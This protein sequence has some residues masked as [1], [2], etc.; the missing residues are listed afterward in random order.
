MNSFEVQAKVLCHFN[1]KSFNLCRVLSGYRLLELMNTIRE[2]SYAVKVNGADKK[3]GVD[4]CSNLELAR[5]LQRSK[6]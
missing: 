5:R 3:Y 2:Q 6:Q 1:S 4:H